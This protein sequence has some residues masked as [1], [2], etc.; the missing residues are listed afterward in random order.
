MWDRVR[1][2]RSQSQRHPEGTIMRAGRRPGCRPLLEFLEG[3]QLLTSATLQPIAPVNVPAMQGTTVPLLAA[4][5]ATDAQTY[6]VTS[7]NPD[8]AASIATGP[9]WN[10]GI[11]YTDPANAANDFTGSLTSQ[12][13]QSLTPTTVTNIS[14][15]TNDGYFVNSGMFFNRIVAGFVVQGGSP[16]LTGDEPNPPVSFGTEFVQQLAFTGTNQLGMAHSS[17]PDSD[18]SQFFITQAPQNSLDYDF[19]MF[20]Q[21]LTGVDT[22]ANMTNMSKVP[23]IFNQ[24]LKETSQPMYPIT[25]TSA[26]LSSTNPNGTLLID[27]TQA[28]QDETSIITVTAT[29]PTNGTTATQTFQ[30]SVGM[31]TRRAH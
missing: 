15:L 19:T 23:L 25:I 30:V 22:I 29:D 26:T 27:T 9:F 8:V 6:T 4:S 10:L 16:T 31:P 3:R 18:T 12:L 11:S 5:G 2:S 17:Q 21:L 13:L 1:G 14:N 24:V 7:S 20:G 28:V